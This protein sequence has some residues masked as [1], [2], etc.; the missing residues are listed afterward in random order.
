MAYANQPE[1]MDQRMAAIQKEATRRLA[2]QKGKPSDMRNMMQIVANEYKGKEAA[3]DRSNRDTS[4]ELRMPDDVNAY[5]DKVLG[6]SGMSGSGANGV[7]TPPSRPVDPTSAVSS[8]R[9]DLGPPT[10]ETQFANDAVNPTSTNIP[11]EDM[12]QLGGSDYL[13]GLLGLRANNF[14]VFDP[15]NRQ[16]GAGQTSP[17]D[18]ATTPADTGAGTGTAI[19]DPNAAATSVADP[20]S[21]FTSLYSLNASQNDD[22]FA[23]MQAELETAPI[24]EWRNI[25]ERYG[26]GINDPAIRD[27]LAAASNAAKAAARKAF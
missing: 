19:A 11:P 10:G 15:K 18:S 8:N 9:E 14:D 27:V 17:A 4:I 7:P 2:A 25:V 23:R 12:M 26:W 20:N 1:T 3:F 13:L 21:D 16:P 24:A 6:M 5:I 22:S